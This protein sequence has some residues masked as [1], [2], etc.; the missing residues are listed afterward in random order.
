[1]PYFLKS[2]DKYTVTSREA[3]DLHERLPTG[4]YSVGIDP[5]G[6]YFFQTIQPFSISGKL[7]GDTT[8]N[9][10]RILQTYLS[11]EA[12]TGI[13]LA[14]EKGS[15]K[16]LLAKHLSIQAAKDHDIPTI[17]VNK[18][19]CGDGFSSF[20]QSIEQPTVVIFDEFEKV[21][22]RSDQQEAML[23]LL[24]GI[25]PSKKLFI[26]TCNDKKRVNIN[27]KN[28]PGRVFYLLDFHG[29]NQKFIREYCDDNLT[30]KSYIEAVC[31]TAS[32]FDAFNFDMLKAMVEEMNRYEE[33]PSDV[34]KFL[35]VRPVFEGNK[36]FLYVLRQKGEIKQES[37]EWNGQPL[38][39]PIH[40]SY[41]CEKCKK[42]HTFTFK[43]QDLSSMDA[44]QGRFTFVNKE[45]DSQID[46]S[47]KKNT[48]VINYDNLVQGSLNNSIKLTDQKPLNGTNQDGHAE[49]TVL[50]E[51]MV[52]D[53]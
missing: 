17:V 26:L 36:R 45:N 3:L 44:S 52:A 42:Q 19:L 16:T 39:S 47:E 43:T 14:G 38:L 6:N 40:I 7:Y 5:N 23:T 21:Y 25:Y 29:L 48:F 28:R 31:N 10:S 27:M 12:S 34:L 35:N 15:G 1:M 51:T 50:D 49:G 22:L 2:G 41:F 32:L 53:Y 46:L 30:N 33:G 13:L 37:K 4:T 9:S 24:D 18:P 11:R 20:L 8:R